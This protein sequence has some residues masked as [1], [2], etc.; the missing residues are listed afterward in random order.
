MGVIT[1][2]LLAGY[3]PFDRDS[4]QLEMEA[5]IAGDYKFEP[6]EYWHNVSPTAKEFIKTCLT[7][8]PAK[9]PTA[10]VALQHKVKWCSFVRPFVMLKTD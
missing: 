6:E 7:N 10:T 1:Y 2:F 4:Q 5:I 9:R 3:T 8:D